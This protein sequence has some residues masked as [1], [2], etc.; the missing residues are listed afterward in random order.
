MKSYFIFDVE[1]IGL[2]GE[3]FAVA[4]GVYLENG[5]TQWEFRA[6]CPPEAAQGSDADRQWVS[7]N[8]PRMEYFYN[9]PRRVR[10]AFWKGWIKARASGAEM[11][12]ECLWPVEAGFVRA[13]IADDPARTWEGPYPF[14]E[15][16]SFMAAAGMDPMGEYERTAS[17]MPKH[18]PLADAR[19]SA[20]LLSEAIA[21]IANR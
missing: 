4:G 18:E 3:G 20:R 8:V 11:A 6:A 12:A 5:A 15:I 13:C 19:Q 7:E 9:T 1:S 2:H 17:E 10:D 21:K 14:H 16:A